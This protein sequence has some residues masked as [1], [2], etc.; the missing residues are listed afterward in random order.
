MNV[1][2][3]G[4]RLNK[5]QARGTVTGKRYSYSANGKIFSVD[6]ADRVQFQGEMEDGKPKF[7]IE[8]SAVD[9][10]GDLTDR[11]SLETIATLTIEN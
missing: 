2:Y 5:R 9:E 3:L 1:Q 7:K 4:T 10:Y 6:P 8:D 11:M